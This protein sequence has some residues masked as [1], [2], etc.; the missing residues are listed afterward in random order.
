MDTVSDIFDAFGGPAAVARAIKV[1]PST[2]S[3][4]KRRGSIPAE[5]WRDLVAGAR[6]RNIGGVSAD[7]LAAIHARRRRGEDD[8]AAA[9]APTDDRDPTTGEAVTGTG[10]FSRYR[11]LRRGHFP[12]GDDV[13]D[14]VHGLR[15]EWD[16]RK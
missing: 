16:R 4:M 12:S 5:Y 3:E 10:H 1:R 7:A 8:D 11:H 15:E 14:H 6:A 13:V 2:A 9:G